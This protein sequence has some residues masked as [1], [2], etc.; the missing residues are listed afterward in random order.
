MSLAKKGEAGL[1][2]WPIKWPRPRMRRLLVTGAKGLNSRHGRE[3]GP[4]DCCGEW[5][6][7]RYDA[8]MYTRCFGWEL[9]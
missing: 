6:T 3:C 8:R 5:P 2:L 4:E 9:S 7:G 1:S